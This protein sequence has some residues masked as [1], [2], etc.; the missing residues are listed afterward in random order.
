MQHQEVQCILEFIRC[1]GSSESD[2]VILKTL[3]KVC[4]EGGEYQR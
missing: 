3:T 4:F 2:T 1:K